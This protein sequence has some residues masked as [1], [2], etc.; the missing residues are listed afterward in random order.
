MNTEQKQ[1]FLLALD[2][3]YLLGGVIVSEWTTFLVRD[4]DTAFCSHANLS[5]ILAA[6][7]AIECHLR[8]EYAEGGARLGFYELIEQS[9]LRPELKAE[10][11]RLRRFRNRW[12]H[13]NDPHDDSSL[14]SRSE[15]H[16]AE[17]EGMAESAM[18]LLRQVLYLEQ[19]L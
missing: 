11:H 17:I 19:F 13:I 9:P 1:A 14:L 12:V 16:D 15:V 3:E 5:A 6:Q 7:A 2:D 4:V 10:L 18:R 8:Y